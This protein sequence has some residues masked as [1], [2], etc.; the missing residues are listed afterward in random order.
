MV[1][2]VGEGSRLHGVTD[3]P[4]EHP[5]AADLGIERYADRAQRVVGR[6]GDL[7]VAKLRLDVLARNLAITLCACSQ[8]Y[9]GLCVKILL[10]KGIVNK[11]SEDWGKSHEN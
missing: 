1:W 9:L 4:V 3:L 10:H 6:G 11:P 8:T 7:Q 2:V 5:D